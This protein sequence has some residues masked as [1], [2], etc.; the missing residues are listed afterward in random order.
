MWT[1][2]AS[3]RWFA[4]KKGR[5]MH[6]VAAAAPRFPRLSCQ[7]P[8]TRDCTFRQKSHLP[9]RPLPVLFF[10]SRGKNLS[11]HCYAERGFSWHWIGRTVFGTIWQEGRTHTVSGLIFTQLCRR[12]LVRPSLAISSDTGMEGPFLLIRCTSLWESR[13]IH[14]SLS[15]E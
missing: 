12:T 3:N 2:G 6:M 1:T 4:G 8:L 15:R 11:S 14:Q 10:N 9:S 13:S 5:L 7:F